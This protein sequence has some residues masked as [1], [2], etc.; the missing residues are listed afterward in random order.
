MASLTIHIAI[1]NEFLKR[2]PEYD[3]NEF[4]RGT[5]DPDLVEDKT[6]THFYDKE[7]YTDYKLFFDEYNLDK[8]YYAGWY[9][10]LIVDWLFYKGLLNNWENRP[11]KDPNKLYDDY[12]FVNQDII[13]KY[14]LEIVD[15]IKHFMQYRDGIPEIL[16]VDQL[17]DFVDEISQIKLET[18]KND[19][20]NSKY[21][22]KQ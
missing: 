11:D 21:I 20:M 7:Y 13:E 10:H 9:M 4:I 22:N 1:A 3:K 5:I 16:N 17:H 2:N 15:R 12:D 19:I 18:I 14:D 8:G 6:T